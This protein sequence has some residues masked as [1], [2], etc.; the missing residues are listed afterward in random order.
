MRT[1]IPAYL[2]LGSNLDRPD[3]QIERA[4]QA[5]AA[6]PECHLQGCSSLYLSAPVPPCPEQPDYVNAVA[7]LDTRLTPQRLLQEL[8]RI[9]QRQG[10]VRGRER[11]SARTLDLD[12]LLYGTQTIASETLTV[13]HPELARRAFVL[14]PLQELAPGLQLPQLGRLADLLPAVA[15]QPIQRLPGN[16]D[17]ASPP[18]PQ[19]ISLPPN[20]RTAG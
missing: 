1:M 11:G 20:R 4:L 8:Q 3:R 7:R 15:Q 19:H 9:E 6:L 14:L 12:L 10:R 5:L 2:G 17:L 16:P 13:P 18:C